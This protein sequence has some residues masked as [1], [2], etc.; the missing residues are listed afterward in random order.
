MRRRAVAGEGFLACPG[1]C[2]SA[3]LDLSAWLHSHLKWA[4]W[5]SV[6]S[7]KDEDTWDSKYGPEGTLSYGSAAHQGPRD[8][9]EDFVAIVPKA[10]CGYLY[11]GNA[12]NPLRQ[13]CGAP[14]S[15]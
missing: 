2:L 5:S 14:C 13:G 12:G 1:G 4:E 3:G 9:M 7:T 8:S 11:A 6:L 10:R 15:R